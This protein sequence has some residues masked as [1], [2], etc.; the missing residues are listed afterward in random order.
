MSRWSDSD[1]LKFCD[2]VCVCVY[3]CVCFF[4]Q[5]TRGPIRT[6]RT[7]RISFECFRNTAS[8]QFVKI[9]W[10]HEVNRTGK[11]DAE[12]GGGG[13][14]RGISP[15]TH[16]GNINVSFPLENS[17]SFLSFYNLIVFFWI[18]FLRFSKFIRR[19]IYRT[20]GYF[21]SVSKKIARRSISFRGYA[22]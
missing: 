12:V 10:I 5:W 16:L 17:I 2:T 18:S 15:P 4:S 1:Y 19:V 14:R 20:R 13:S 3:V 21:G 6:Y 11:L 7:N 8:E 22:R 9:F